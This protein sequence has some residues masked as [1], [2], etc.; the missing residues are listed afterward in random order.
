MLSWRVLV[1]L[2]VVVLLIIGYAFDLAWL[3]A[4]VVVATIAMLI[5]YALG[6]LA[7]GQREWF[8]REQRRR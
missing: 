8:D 4:L 3:V 7:R 5:F 1:A 2:L 6:L